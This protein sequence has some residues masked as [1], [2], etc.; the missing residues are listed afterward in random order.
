MRAT[1]CKPLYQAFT[2]R[3]NNCFSSANCL[4][5]MLQPLR[6]A[7]SSRPPTASFF[8]TGRSSLSIAAL[9]TVVAAA[10]GG[11]WWWKAR[12]VP[13][14]GAAL[15]G[16]S[17]AASGPV[18]G[19]T[20]A[21]SGAGGAGRR[22]GGSNRAQPV[23]VQAVRQQDMRVLVNAIGNVTALN[24]AVARARVDGE[25]RS[26]RFKE[27]QQVKAGA[28]LAEIDPRSFEVALA[29]AQAAYNRD[30]ALL[31]N[32]Q[33]DLD[34]YKDLLAKDSI[35]KQQVDTQDAQVKQLQATLMA[36]QASVDNAKL[37]LSYTKVTAPIGGRLGL[38]QLDLGN[39]VRSSDANGLV[40]INQT[41]PI[42]AVFAV[43][44]INL[45]QINRQLK[46][47]TALTVEAWDREQRV[48][49]ATGK[50]IATDNAVDA[51]TG[52]IKLKASFANADDSL[53]P[54]QFINIRMQVDTVEAAIAVPSNAVQRGAQGTFVYVAKDDGTVSMRRVRLGVTEGDWVAVQGEVAAGEKVVTDG[55]DR[56]REGA[57]VEV[58]APQ[59]G[60]GA[61]FGAGAGA[62]AGAGRRE[63]GAGAGAPAQGAS[64][65]A[66]GKPARDAAA[67][68]SAGAPPKPTESGAKPPPAAAPSAAAPAAGARADAWID[69]LPPQAQDRIRAM[70][71]RIGP[72]AAAK[73]H[74]MSPDERREYFQKLRAQREA[75]Q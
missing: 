22:F 47:G 36:D 48:K 26:V 45:P 14:P 53:F 63:G 41:Q 66:V 10:G 18:A 23:S 54:N 57:K 19:A 25:L 74:K 16:A 69:N 51:A 27:G 6:S 42:G 46:A 8:Q 33:L 21:A 60:P 9:V 62:G 52:T 29:Q 43:P 58:I 37:Q 7:P 35:A 56:L 72:E 15:A 73:V 38:R 71:E 5:A 44:E 49:L 3:P 11:A 40:S 39:I 1:L 34:R 64:A 65:A 20:A 24:T 17:G 31:R 59:R 28:L 55:A 68:P 50:I 32:A 67:A 70:L 13:E 61:G 75:Q 4:H 2:M 12:Q 30:Q